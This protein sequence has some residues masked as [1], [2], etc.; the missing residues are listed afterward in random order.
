MPFGHHSSI[1]GLKLGTFTDICFSG[2]TAPESVRQIID[3]F[4]GGCKLVGLVT[5][6][7]PSQC[8]YL[9]FG[10]F[11]GIPQLESFCLP[12]SVEFIDCAFCGANLPFLLPSVAA[13]HVFPFFHQRL[14]VRAGILVLSHSSF[15]D[16]FNPSWSQFCTSQSDI[17]SPSML[18]QSSEVVLV[19]L[20]LF[21]LEDV[22]ASREI[23]SVLLISTQ[24]LCYSL[25]ILF[26]QFHFRPIP[27]LSLNQ[28]VCLDSQ[29]LL[30]ARRS[31]AFDLIEILL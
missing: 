10:G 11:Q 7:L 1:S 5:F 3:Y 25:R 30:I 19:P 9:A 12:P 4:F 18:K 21:F 23:W 29:R 22:S 2:I 13:F 28:S 14:Y 15:K 20:K 17:G 27:F 31:L 8:S 24:A 6:E 16:N 26:G